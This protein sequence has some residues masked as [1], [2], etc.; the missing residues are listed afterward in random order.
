MR[1]FSVGWPYVAFSQK[2]NYIVLA[3]AFDRKCIQ[4]I[5]ICE[6][7]DKITIL[8]SY[9]TDTYDLFI[10]TQELEKNCGCQ[11][12]FKLYMIDLDAS[13]PN[14]N[15]HFNRKKYPYKLGKPIFSYTDKDVEER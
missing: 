5:Q 9:I 4:R 13:N 1:A 3:N 6:E 8:D 14:K 2:S 12:T 10:L 15:G 7:G 11:Q